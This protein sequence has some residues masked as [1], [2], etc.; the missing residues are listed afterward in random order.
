MWVWNPDLLGGDLIV[1]HDWQRR[2]YEAMLVELVRNSLPGT[3]Q[4]PPPQ[5]DEESYHGTVSHRR[6]L[7]MKLPE[8]KGCPGSFSV[9]HCR[10]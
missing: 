3:C 4:N 7:A 1:A 6:Y 2:C 9:R 5:D 8:E 10:S